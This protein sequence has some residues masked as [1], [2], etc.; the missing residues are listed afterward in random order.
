MWIHLERRGEAAVAMLTSPFISIRK[1]QGPP[2]AQRT[3]FTRPFLKLHVKN[4]AQGHHIST[5]DERDWL[6]EID[7][8]PRYAKPTQRV[9]RCLGDRENVSRRAFY[10]W[11]KYLQRTSSSNE[12]RMS[13]GSRWH[14][15]CPQID[16]FGLCFSS[17]LVNSLRDGGWVWKREGGRRGVAFALLFNDNHY[18]YN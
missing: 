18:Q 9:K 14:S 3:P 13:K 12:L 16:V 4:S 6:T 7:V 17:L 1:A 5:L 15:K 11:P 2:K 10:H 8:I